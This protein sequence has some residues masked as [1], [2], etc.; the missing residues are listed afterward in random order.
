MLA[1]SGAF[2]K[3]F[4]PLSIRPFSLVI[5]YMDKFLYN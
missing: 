4:R 3:C 2:D 5:A 1:K